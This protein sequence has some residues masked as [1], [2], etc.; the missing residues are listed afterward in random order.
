MEES[1][2]TDLQFKAY[3][4]LIIKLLENAKSQP[5]KEATDESLDEL[6]ADFKDD[7]SF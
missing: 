6:I 4:R 5:T 2:M 3:T 7:L 1:G